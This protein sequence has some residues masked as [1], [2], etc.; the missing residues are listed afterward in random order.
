M[1]FVAINLI[2]WYTI[3]SVL[4]TVLLLFIVEPLNKKFPIKV[5]LLPKWV[6]LLVAPITPLVVAGF[7]I[8]SFIR[9]Q[10]NKKDVAK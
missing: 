4:C 10:R 8:T 1:S 6:M 2:A 7:L 3:F 9:I 5:P